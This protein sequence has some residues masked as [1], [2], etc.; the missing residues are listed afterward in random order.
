MDNIE[1]EFVKNQER[2]VAAA[3]AIFVREMAKLVSIMA[4]LGIQD[5]A[6]ASSTLK[7]CP[8][9]GGAPG[10]TR[11]CSVVMA[12]TAT[13]TTPK[14]RPA[15]KQNKPMP[16]PAAKKPVQKNAHRGL[17]DILSGKRPEI[18]KAIRLIL[19]SRSMS[20]SQIL[21]EM[22]KR[23]WMPQSGN[24]AVY[25]GSTLSKLTKDGMLASTA[26]PNTNQKR[27]HVVR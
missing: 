1:I 7:R 14:N 3:K 27:Y 25:V 18:R 4:V 16:M 24:P 2:K 11:T 17:R 13:Q 8:E 21:A 19:G 9:C 15:T 23:D 6:R 10:H 5:D 22:K 12:A 20:R 26:I